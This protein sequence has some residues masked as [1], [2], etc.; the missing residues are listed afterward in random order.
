MSGLELIV[1]ALAAGA[2]A[3]VT[4]TA[5]DVIR[6]SYAGLKS[7]LAKRLQSRKKTHEALKADTVDPD[8]WRERIGADLTASG[9]DSDEEVLAAAR[10]LLALTE[11]ASDRAGSSTVIE[12][13]Y[14]PSGTFNAP[15]S[16]V[17]NFNFG[18]PTPPGTV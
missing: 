10:R 9:A 18:P 7:L 1:A 3:G 13:N 12:N 16:P 6:D 2:A 8:V 4:D 5:G 15:V 14:G 17:Y 11:R